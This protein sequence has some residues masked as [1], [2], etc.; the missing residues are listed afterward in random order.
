MGS[1]RPASRFVGADGFVGHS[2]V[3]QRCVR[4][5]LNIPWWESLR[6][7]LNQSLLCP[8]RPM[9]GRS[10]A[11]RS[12]KTTTTTKKSCRLFSPSFSSPAPFSLPRHLPTLC[13]L[14]FLP[15]F[16]PPP[17]C[18]ASSFLT[19]PHCLSLWSVVAPSQEHLMSQKRF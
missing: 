9:L 16:F 4:R 5:C 8:H 10:P 12:A 2:G 6:I 13:S 14:F 18:C 19:F 3:S 7:C 11:R 1:E 17:V 15:T